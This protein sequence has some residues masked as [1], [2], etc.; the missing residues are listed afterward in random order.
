[1][2]SLLRSLRKRLKA[3]PPPVKA[4]GKFY[5][6]TIESVSIG[7]RKFPVLDSVTYTTYAVP[8]PRDADRPGK[9]G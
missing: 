6:G 3:N 8:W 4:K 2:S 1:M 7:G 9:P 5:P